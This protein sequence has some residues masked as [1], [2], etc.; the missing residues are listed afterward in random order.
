MFTSRKT[1][2]ETIS[3]YLVNDH[4]RCEA[5]F[6]QVC[7]ALEETQWSQAARAF[8]CFDDA[9]ERHLLIEERVVYPAY[10][11]AIH[12]LA[13]PTAV[14]RSE[15]LTIRALAQRLAFALNKH[16][17]SE[18]SHLAAELQ[19]LLCLHHRAE[20]QRLFPMLERVLAE[21]QLQ[22]LAA[23]HQFGAMETVARAA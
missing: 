23:M 5:L 7:A 17:A 16:L 4:A 18:A 12:D 21:R 10:E 13:T 19:T 22:L 2:V 20:E 6:T 14:R 15:H 9:L 1:I 8:S 3:T 11:N